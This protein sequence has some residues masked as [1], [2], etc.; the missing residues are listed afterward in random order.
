M[1][2]PNRLFEDWLGGRASLGAAG[3]WTAE[4]LR[5]VADIGYAL[6]EQGRHDEAVTIFEGLAVLAPATA[7]FQSALGALW[8]RKGEPARA[9][10]HLEAALAAD[11]SDVTARVNRGEAA[12]QLGDRE[13]A[14]RDLLAAL[15]I[16][17][18]PPQEGSSPALVRARALL[19][20]L[21]P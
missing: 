10:E 20:Q 3:G 7:Y 8:L 16:G 19:A 21:N 11:P 4:E 1:M 9:L 13:A 2:T 6:A 5:L 12:L 18:R 14:R 15:D 17:P